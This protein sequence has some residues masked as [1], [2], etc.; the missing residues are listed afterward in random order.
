MV[1]HGCELCAAQH[2]PSY[3]EWAAKS[4]SNMFVEQWTY[5][6]NA[7]Q[8]Q[9]ACCSTTSTDN[10]WPRPATRFLTHGVGRLGQVDDLRSKNIGQEP[11]HRHKHTPHQASG[12]N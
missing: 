8:L 9:L 11:L 3:K 6:P 10:N 4:N 12:N 2:Q 5:M 1:I 7:Q